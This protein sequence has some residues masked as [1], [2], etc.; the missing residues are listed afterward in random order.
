MRLTTTHPTFVGVTVNTVNFV[1]FSI[2]YLLT[3]VFINISRCIIFRKISLSINN[4]L[5]LDE[6]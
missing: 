4:L 1:L 5:E 3:I 2:I 6:N